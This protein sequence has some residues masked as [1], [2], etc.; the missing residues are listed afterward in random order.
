[1]EPEF[2]HEHVLVAIEAGVDREGELCVLVVAAGIY[3]LLV[4]LRQRV[5]GRR[6][7][8]ARLVGVRE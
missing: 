3:R 8:A 6:R 7:H 2:P 1:M 4:P 5:R